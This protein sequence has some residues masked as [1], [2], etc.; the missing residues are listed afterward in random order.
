MSLLDD[1]L[2]HEKSRYRQLW[3]SGRLVD[4]FKRTFLMDSVTPQ[5]GSILFC[6]LFG[7]EHSGIY[8]GN[9]QIVELTRNG[10]I[11]KTDAPGFIEGTN[12][13][14]IYV[15][16]DGEQA[17]SSRSTATRALEMANKSRSYNPVLDN[18][19]Q[20]TT[21]CI[22]GDFENSINFF[23]MLETEVEKHL[24]HSNDITWRR[25]DR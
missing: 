5:I 19:H 4:K 20:F 16:C 18:C 21:G 14:Q 24:N 25:W 7:F 13:I 8:V 23:W 10:Q 3:G 6:E 9:G 12:A 22:T 2:N 17:I 11:R 15:S 1:L